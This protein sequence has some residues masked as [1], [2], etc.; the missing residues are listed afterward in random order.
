MGN[1]CTSRAN[2]EAVE[3][4]HF[5]YT[6]GKQ[7]GKGSQG[8][9]H[10]CTERRSGALL[11]VKVIVRS[12]SAET[13][14]SFLKE[15]ELCRA[16]A[17][18]KGAE[19]ARNVIRVLEEF[20]D[21][22]YWYV[23]MDKYAGNL[24]K[25]LKWV[26]Q[27]GNVSVGFDSPVIWH[28]A[29]QVMSA[30]SHL[31]ECHVV[32]R[33][34]KA[35]NLLVDRLD[36]LDSG[37]RVVLT[38]LGLARR[39][40]PGRF[41]SA[42]VGTRKYWAP[43][44]YDNKYKHVVDVF[45]LGVLLFFMATAFYPYADEDELRTRDIFKEGLMPEAM[46]CPEHTKAADARD[47]LQ[48]L[49]EKDPRLRSPASELVQHPWLMASD[50][51]VDCGGGVGRRGEAGVQWPMAPTANEVVESA[52]PAQKVTDFGPRARPLLES[53]IAACLGDDAAELATSPREAQLLQ[54]S[55]ES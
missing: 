18:W 48:R 49:L 17:E 2:D 7:I 53:G 21:E 52:E 1:N 26:A 42:Q 20:M 39:L 4:F 30:I 35:H 8:R 23:V 27:D 14:T 32:H 25:G 40:E 44:I 16:V 12:K 54:A 38:D 9:V 51:A 33:D 37:F 47:F 36:L 10:L 19:R 5:K 46:P 43:E 3:G 41:L 45:A 22:S 31:H 50:A 28:V 24:R 13:S 15:F 55:M 6:L 34:V 11:A 29:K